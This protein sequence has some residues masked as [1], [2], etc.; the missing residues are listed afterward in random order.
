M[1]K[2]V[3][4]RWNVWRLNRFIAAANKGVSAE[5]A[6]NRAFLSPEETYELLQS[7]L[8]GYLSGVGVLTLGGGRSKGLRMVGMPPRFIDIEIVCKA[9]LDL[10]PILV[11]GQQQELATTLDELIHHN[12]GGV[13]RAT[14][15]AIQRHNGVTA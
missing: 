12:W 3:K 13:R 11:E 4:D 14:T 7:T 6:V 5:I 9:L 1:L 10:K 8:N 15:T 2:F